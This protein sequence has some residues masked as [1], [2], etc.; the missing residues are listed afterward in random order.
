[1]KKLLSICIPTYNRIDDLSEIVDA[2]LTIDNFD[3]EIVI[4]DNLSTDTTKE[5]ILSYSDPRVRY[6]LNDEALPPFLNMIHSIFNADGKYA[7]YCND[8]DILYPDGII[9]L[10][11][12]LKDNDFAFLYSPAATK[13]AT[14]SF[15]IFES[16]FD[17]LMNF[18]CIHHPTGMVYN[19]EL[20]SQYLTEDDYNNYL[21]YINTYDFLMLDLFKYGKSICYSGNYWSPRAAEYIK[22]NKSGTIQSNKKLYFS[23]EVR[24][25]MFYGIVEHIFIRNDY[26][27]TDDKKLKLLKKVYFEFCFLFCK[28]KACM[29]DANET[30]HYGIKTKHISTIHI[31]K[32]FTSFL[33][34]S[35]DFLLKRDFDFS[36]I[37]Y[38]KKQ[39][40]NLYFQIVKNC[41]K[42]DLIQLKKR[43]IK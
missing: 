19:R 16:G 43:L 7:L 34:R 5:K 11:K 41:I 38:A 23:P 24:E 8:R 28:Y 4:T 29:A 10:M 26:N 9:K 37:N 3:F 32:I 39:R 14:N 42:I 30:T 18:A 40:C 27:L 31:L 25:H 36:L 2:I 33:N 35:F 1:M 21:Q 20:I 22:K 15:S 12:V 6:C 13:S 17:S